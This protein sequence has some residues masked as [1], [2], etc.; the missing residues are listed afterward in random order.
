MIRAFYVTFVVNF[1]YVTVLSLRVTVPITRRNRLT[2]GPSVSKPRCLP[3]TVEKRFSS[4]LET[5]RHVQFCNTFIII[6]YISLPR[7]GGGRW[8]FN[9]LHKTA[10]DLY[11]STQRV[12]FPQDKIKKSVPHRTYISGMGNR[13]SA[14]LFYLA[15]ATFS[16][17]FI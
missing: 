11:R 13:R 17:N 7:H 16:N 15:S 6:L 12:A 9:R 5:K 14:Y 1:D 2:F 8:I 10:L 3:T 4:G